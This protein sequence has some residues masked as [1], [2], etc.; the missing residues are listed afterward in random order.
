M[1]GG[2]ITALD[3]QGKAIRKSDRSHAIV[4]SRFLGGSVTTS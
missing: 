1:G 3:H 2:K 4:S